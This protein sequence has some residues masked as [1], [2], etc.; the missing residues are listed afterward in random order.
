MAVALGAA[1]DERVVRILFK[2]YR[3]EKVVKT[4]SLDGATTDADVEAILTD[5]DTLSNSGVVKSSVQTAIGATGWGAAVN[6]LQSSVADIMALTFTQVDPVNAANTITKSFIVPAYVDAL[7]DTDFKPVTNNATLNDLITK[8]EAN[9]AFKGSDGIIYAGGW[10]YQR[11]MSGFGKTS[12][13]I[14]GL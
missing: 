14:D 2:D 4:F 11:N 3:T 13:E 6:A 12:R 9:L 5:I 7:M 10:T 8:L 1:A